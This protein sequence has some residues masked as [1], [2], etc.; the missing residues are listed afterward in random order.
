MV[1]YLHILHS[2]TIDALDTRAGLLRRLVL[3]NAA[4]KL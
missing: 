1:L 2:V 3:P 4:L